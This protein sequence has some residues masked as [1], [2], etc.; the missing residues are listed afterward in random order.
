MCFY[1]L[2]KKKNY[3][4]LLFIGELKMVWSFDA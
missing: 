1:T 2:F 3:K 4:K